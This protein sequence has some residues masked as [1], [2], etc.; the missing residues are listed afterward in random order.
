[1]RAK[2]LAAVTVLAVGLFGIAMAQEAPPTPPQGAGQGRGMRGNFRGVG[3]QITA[4]DGSTITLETFRGETAKVKIT[5]STRLVKDGNEA[6]LSEFKVGD[7][8]FAAGEQ[9]KDGAWIAQMFGQRTTFVAGPRHGMMGG[10]Q[11]S[12]KITARPTF[13]E[14]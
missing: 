4:I 3:G 7:R 1:M 6:K 13:S 14:S 11:A 5:S 2:M 10:A 9:D 12:R 8:V